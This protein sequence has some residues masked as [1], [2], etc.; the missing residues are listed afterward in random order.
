M[1]A[2]LEGDLAVL[3]LADQSALGVL[4]FMQD[5]ESRTIAQDEELA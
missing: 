1:V 3:G 5:A 4:Q 2:R